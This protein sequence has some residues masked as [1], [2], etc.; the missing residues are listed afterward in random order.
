M[1]PS[2]NLRPEHQILYSSED[3]LES[4][5]PFL[6][7]TFLG[8]VADGRELGLEH[9]VVAAERVLKVQ[10]ERSVLAVA[11]DPVDEP[12]G[13]D[14]EA[15][16]L[17]PQL[18]QGRVVLELGVSALLQADAS[19]R[20]LRL[21]VHLVED[22]ARRAIRFLLGCVELIVVPVRAAGV[23]AVRQEERG[24]ERAHGEEQPSA[25]HVRCHRA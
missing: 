8:H 11:H 15:D 23:R 7:A 16:A 14:D 19:R 12:Q 21:L 25:P 2:Q 10:R 5:E 22:L 9:A 6:G 20:L 4:T 24:D 17:V 3:S 13:H 1:A 18:E